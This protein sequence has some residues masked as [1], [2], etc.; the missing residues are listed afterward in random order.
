MVSEVALEATR[1]VVCEL[2]K[3]TVVT[4][5]ASIEPSTMHS[6]VA[7]TTLADQEL[8]QLVAF[9]DLSPE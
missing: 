7:M 2:L 9:I 8:L 6:A 1:L 5:R 4:A 3:K